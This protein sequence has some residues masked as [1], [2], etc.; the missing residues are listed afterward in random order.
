MKPYLLQVLKE[1][2]LLGAINSRIEI[3][4]GELAF[5]LKTSQ[6]TA[7]RYL[8]ELDE[9][10][11]IKRELGVKKQMIHITEKGA[12]VL[13]DEY[14]QYQHIFEL[15][16][17]IHFSGIIVS[18]M[19]EGRYYTEQKGY[20]I[21]FKEKLGFIP[22]PGTLNVEIKPVDKNKLRL[23]KKSDTIRIESFESDN[24]TFGEVRCFQA[25]INNFQ[26]ILVL[27]ARGHYSTILEFIAPVY[28]REKLNIQD[29]DIVEVII[30][31]TDGEKS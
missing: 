9:M 3:A 21:Q 26:C 6:Q 16:R 24:R 11:M 8:L 7:S 2:A 28:L 4:S 23:L 10:D 5:Q 18:G 15:P 12:D 30:S 22:Y 1:L 14:V 27:P 17:K 25:T 20:T 31:L 19:G 29:G 13:R